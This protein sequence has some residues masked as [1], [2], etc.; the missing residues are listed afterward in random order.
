[1]IEHLRNPPPHFEKIVKLHFRLHRDTI[2]RET[3]VWVDE[4]S[5]ISRD[6]FAAAHDALRELLV[7]LT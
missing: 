1:M 5:S 7:A 2:L 3:R 4:A 6:A